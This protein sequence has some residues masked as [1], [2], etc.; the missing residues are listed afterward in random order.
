M[1][2]AKIKTLIDNTTKE[3]IA[4]RTVLEAITA[5]GKKGQVIGF[6]A[7]NKIAPITLPRI[8]YNGLEIEKIEL[9]DDYTLSFYLTN[10]DIVIT[11]YS[12]PIPYINNEG[13]W[14]IGNIDTKKPARGEQGY[15]PYIQNNYWYIN[16]QNTN[17]KALGVDGYTPYIDNTSKHWFING[18]DSNIVA[19][20]KDGDSPYIGADGYWYV[21]GKKTDVKA[22]GP[23]GKDGNV[24]I[25][26]GSVGSDIQPVYLDKGILKTSTGTVGD[27]S[28]PIYLS[29]GQFVPATNVQTSGEYLPLS[30]GTITGN[31][32]VT[33]NVTGNKVYGA[34]WNDYAECRCAESVEPGRVV[35]E[36]QSGCMKLSTERLQPGANIISDTFGTLIGYTQNTRTPIAVSGRVLAYPAEDRQSYE[37]GCA[38]CSGPNGTISKMTREEIKEYPERIIGTVSEIPEYEIW[39][40]GAIS[41]NGRIWI[42]VR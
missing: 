7:D 17:V 6:T 30:G 27:D 15:I 32:T 20:G 9:N 3:N 23:Q 33:G 21:K 26:E 31:L 5:F 39:G 19:E 37:L 25:G 16:G 40:T 18:V 24:V 29:N 10:G 4:P 12:L 34:V 1:P 36:D 8:Q 14:Q 13:N 22:Q 38:V 41:V 2:E 28:T 11:N 35:I 42:K